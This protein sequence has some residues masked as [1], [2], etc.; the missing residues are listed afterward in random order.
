MFENWTGVAKTCFKPLVYMDAESTVLDT[1]LRLSSI[2][3]NCFA[4]GGSVVFYHHVV[5]TYYGWDE[6][7]NI[8]TYD[9]DELSASEKCHRLRLWYGHD[10]FMAPQ[11]NPDTMSADHTIFETI[12]WLPTLLIVVCILYFGVSWAMQAKPLCLFPLCFDCGTR[13][14]LMKGNAELGDATAERASLQVEAKAAAGRAAARTKALVTGGARTAG[15]EKAAENQTVTI[16]GF[17]QKLPCPCF[18]DVAGVFGSIWNHTHVYNVMIVIFFSMMVQS[19]AEEGGANHDQAYGYAVQYENVKDVTL[20]QFL[21]GATTWPTTSTGTYTAIQKTGSCVPTGSLPFACTSSQDI[22]VSQ[23]QSDPSSTTL[24]GLVSNDGDNGGTN[25]HAFLQ[26]A[27]LSYVNTDE[28]DLSM[29]DPICWVDLDQKHY[30]ALKQTLLTASAD[31]QLPSPLIATISTSS[32][33]TVLESTAAKNAHG[34]ALCSTT[35]PTPAAS[36]TYAHFRNINDLLTWTIKAQ[37]EV[38]LEYN[39]PVVCGADV[40][41][42]KIKS[43][44][45]KDEDEQGRCFMHEEGSNVEYSDN[46]DGVNQKYWWY[47]TSLHKI[48]LPADTTLSELIAFAALFGVFGASV[49][50]LARTSVLVSGLCFGVFPQVDKLVPEVFTSNSKYVENVKSLLPF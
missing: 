33:L 36:T 37:G 2:L 45:L 34:G 26:D 9:D 27:L 29:W 25:M 11:G 44:A 5:Q 18:G 1:I 17:L 40:I 22:Y 21:V 23:C 3:F 6:D 4:L 16:F 8:Q 46:E 47:G 15:T 20:D 39:R 38:S 30:T 10:R 49:G 7:G 19:V 31:T 14:G 43:C 48:F 32:S 24:S 28:S 12:E 13:N 35:L 50:V 41:E 42:E